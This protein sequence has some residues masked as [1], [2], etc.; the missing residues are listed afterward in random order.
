MTTATEY[1]SVPNFP[2]VKVGTW[3]SASGPK[4]VTKE[5]LES[6]VEA[7][8]SQSLDKAVIKKGHLDPRHSN[9]AWDGEPAYGQV[10]N[11]RLSD[12]G[13]TLLGDYVNV[14]KDLADSLPSAYPNRSV[15]I[16]WGVQL[17][18]AAGK[19]NKK[20]K[21]A[22][23]GV[24]LLGRTPPAVKGLGGPVSA[25]SGGL[26][27]DDVAVFSTTDFSL[28]GGLTGNQLREAIDKAITAEFRRPS[29]PGDDF[30]GEYPWLT[31]Y[32][33]T[34][35]WFRSNGGV[36]QV[37][38]TADDSGT[39]ALNDDVV[40]V[41]ERRTFVPV[42]DTPTVP[43]T[44][45]SGAEAND[46]PGTNANADSNREEPPMSEVLIKLRDKLGLPETATEEEILT[47]AAE[48]DLTP[49]V[50]ES[51]GDST[52]TTGTPAT[53]GGSATTAE[54]QTN[55]SEGGKHAADGTPLEGAPENVTVSK[56]MFSE[57]MEQNR[58]NSAIVKDLV[59]KDK[60]AHVDGLVSK[61]STAGKIHPTEVGYF[62]EQLGKQE[63]ETVAF[64]S[65]RAGIPVDEIGSENADT[66]N[67]S[68]GSHDAALSYFGL[69]GN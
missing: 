28:P 65:A 17:K 68:E 1:V 42:S 8:E 25:M 23:A 5:D 34:T 14:P 13:T 62:R 52:A 48:A 35:A 2:L 3:T 44:N 24:A 6:I 49:K 32:D 69:G 4:S 19:V 58:T 21:A 30:V 29:K 15:E 64:L 46:V 20:F 43:Q 55:A 60:K 63:A 38:Y 16:A 10:D 31:D 11:L 67:F 9:P 22:L 50:E 51:K 26:E 66:V 54:A 39:I 45:L 36:F 53:A 59:E 12:D 27:C 37:T 47:A 41:V 56:A 18:D 33:D 40:E 61:F 7:H 57:L